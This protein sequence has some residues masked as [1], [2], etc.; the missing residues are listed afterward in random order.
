MVTIAID[1]SQPVGG[2]ALA[3]NGQVLGEVHFGPPS[4]H[5]VELPRAVERLLHENNLT[6]NDVGRVAVVLGPG[7]FTGVRIA[8]SFAKGLAAAGK[9]VVAMDSL[10]LIALR[11]FE[12]GYDSVCVMIDAKR[13]EVYGVLLE[14]TVT[15]RPPTGPPLREPTVSAR[16]ASV[17]AFLD[18]VDEADRNRVFPDEQA[19][20]RAQGQQL[21]ML[22]VGTGAIA[23]R[24]A[25]LAR[26]PRAEVGDESRAYPSVY[27][28]AA[29]ACFD[30]A[31]PR[32]VVR[33][34]EPIY[35]RASGA[36]RKRLRAHAPEKKP[37]GD[38]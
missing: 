9:E 28:F 7:S 27:R 3:R 20:E 34:L 11:P 38:D 25:I 5:L 36:E 13:E 2:V 26:F 15:L 35:L 1:T 12:E 30:R 18:A 33:D 16:V 31:L 21:P 17:Q 32:E 6:I 14:N 37:T 29:D 4:S 19:I 10:W 22:F 24:D 23:Y 8:L